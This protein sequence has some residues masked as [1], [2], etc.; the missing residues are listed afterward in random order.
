MYGFVHKYKKNRLC[1]YKQLLET[2]THKIK[3]KIL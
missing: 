3:S 1:V 2:Y